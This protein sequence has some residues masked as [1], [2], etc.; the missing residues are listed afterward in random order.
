[1]A[2]LGS[3]NTSTNSVSGATL[4][5][6]K[7]AGGF[8]FGNNSSGGGLFGANA[9]ANNANTQNTGGLFG[10]STTGNSNFMSNTANQ[11]QQGTGLFGNLNSGNAASNTSN[12]GLLG[13][14]AN[15]Q[16]S[17]L[18]GNNASSNPPTGGLF[19][20]S[21]SSNT[22]GGL[23]GNS[24][25][26][27]A[28]NALGN[29]LLG[30]PA[31]TTGSGG[32]FGNNSQQ[33][34]GSSAPTNGLFGNPLATGTGGLFGSANKPATSGLFG[35]SNSTQTNGLFSNSQTTAQSGLFGNSSN[36]TA[37]NNNAQAWNNSN[38]VANLDPYKSNPIMSSL[39]SGDIEMPQ[40]ITASLF[41]TKPTTQERRSSQADIKPPPKKSSLLGKLA[42]TFNIIRTSA[43]VKPASG[44][45][46]LKGIFTQQNYVTDLAQ[47]RLD[48]V[49]SKKR[50]ASPIKIDNRSIGDVRK[51]VIKSKPIPFHLIDA[52]KVL[53][54]KRRRIAKPLSAKCLENNV[55]TDDESSSDEQFVR[56]AIAPQSTT[57]QNQSKQEE[58]K[59][60][61]ISEDAN[62]Y[63]C[64]PSLKELASFSEEQLSSV[65]NFIIGRKG[66]GQIAYNFPVDLL[67][68]FSKFNGDLSLVQEELFGRIIKI[69]KTV[70]RAYDDPQVESPPMGCELNVPATITLVAPPRPSSTIESHIK[71]LQNITG[72]D[73]V[74]FDPIL[75]N[76]TFKV[77]H[78]SVWGLI[79]DGE[80]EADEASENKRLRE[81]KS[82]QDTQEEE[83][84]NTYSR[85]YE[86]SEFHNELK[87]QKVER[88]TSGLP[89]GWVYDTTA[90]TE[91]A[92]GSLVVKQRLVQNEINQEINQFK[93]GQS[94][95]VLAS[96]ASDI[97][98]ES[99]DESAVA[100]SEEILNET[101]LPNEP[102]QY[103]YLKETLA[104]IPV[105]TH[106]DDLIDEKAYEP[107]IED[108]KA[109]ELVKIAPSVPSLKDWILQLELAN[110]ISSALA[111]P[112]VIED[113]KLALRSV[114]EILFADLSKSSVNLEQA[115]T[116]IKGKLAP[117]LTHAPTD[118]LN[119]T[120]T[121]KLI[122]I[123][124]LQCSL[125]TQTNGFPHLTFS[126]KVSY[127]TFAGSFSNEQLNCYF[128][129]VS[130]LLDSKL[131]LSKPSFREADPSNIPLMKHLESI[132]QR[133]ALKMWLRQFYSKEHSKV[134]TDPLDAVLHYVCVGNINQ[135]IETAITS[136]NL[137]LSTLITL[138][139]S[140]DSAVKILATSQLESW[141]NSVSIG[142]IPPAVVDIHRIL[143]GQYNQLSSPQLP[144]LELALR[145]FY[146]S[147]TDNLKTIIREII[148]T[149]KTPILKEL[150]T[151][152]LS[153][154]DH[155]FIESA[156]VLSSSS[157]DSCFKWVLF[158]ISD[159]HKEAKHICDSV[160]QQFA[161]E[162]ESAGLWKEAIAVA[163]SIEDPI[164]S[165]DSIRAITLRNISKMDPNTNDE[166]QFLE[167]VLR[168]PSAL[169][170]E[171]IS[172]EHRKNNDYWGCC[173]ALVSAEMWEDAHTVLCSELG[174][175]TV[176]GNNTALTLRFF[177]L[178]E[179]FPDH[180]RIITTWN[181]GAGLFAKFF[182][183]TE[184]YEGTPKLS[185]EDILFLL[186]NM[187]LFTVADNN[188]ARVAAKVMSQKIGDMAIE[189]RAKI[190]NLDE[191]ISGLKLGE[192]EKR[193]L[194]VRLLST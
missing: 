127:D 33:N 166:R 12:T 194:S 92:D 152:F 184:P 169:I 11:G 15:T 189:N 50:P 89:G 115:S 144:D 81:L 159:L 123:V 135:A 180:G 142:L 125:Q 186:E 112:L 111:S 160:T 137:H 155:Q 131:P 133:E 27:S 147:N 96:N 117:Q 23:F 114:N 168:V 191:K 58:P 62:G 1:M 182:E 34:T 146:G 126:D 67:H 61:E 39:S 193:Y 44:L 84:N 185:S 47:A 82:K 163:S 102:R 31:T 69:D 138:L 43:S 59:A 130:V 80:D 177:S 26:S 178:V 40:S 171:A 87:R 37:Q 172:T 78:F 145:V 91:N 167:S 175:L 113:G 100:S 36:N 104:G 170:Y 179:K 63:F 9:N 30:Q 143:A 56:K 41:A 7:P 74:T 19:G 16:T 79:D 94:A 14:T 105:S 153:Y 88:Q 64:S 148:L 51:L 53:N 101:F 109:F 86:S 5:Q 129:L 75:Y 4:N 136:S 8:T 139:D 134:P 52:D 150:L 187:A 122:Q 73:F 158:R 156:E 107:D 24:N 93:E 38:S 60:T 149:V 124:L 151:I 121:A 174:P 49:G 162:L 176:I 6:S 132:Q 46:N 18:F 164:K 21:S 72:M 22:S 103:D 45:S 83:A 2:N 66:H 161:G 20:N 17:G 35:N 25:T 128:D 95:L 54:A 110:D 98:I 71:R 10:N 99:D 106:F 108:E 97:T 13:S 55:L 157:F 57:S 68:I 65:F 116:P 48:N 190:T 165:L 119:T 70:V 120:L 188:S 3:L 154:K 85:L 28:P 183:T 32:L 181:Q 77:K 118:T 42:Q 192:N 76:W 29:T 141:K 140:N 173:E 90:V